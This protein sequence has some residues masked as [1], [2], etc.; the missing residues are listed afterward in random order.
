[1]DEEKSHIEYSGTDIL[2][3]FAGRL[4]AAEMHA[5]EKAALDDP[6]LL[7]T[8]LFF[9]S[10]HRQRRD[11]DNGAVNHVAELVGFQDDVER[12]VPRNLA[13]HEID[14]PLDLGIDDDVEAADLL[15]WAAE[16]KSQVGVLEVE[17]DGRT[18]EFGLG[19]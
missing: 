12:L 16:D 10:Q 9:S 18:G 7:A 2:N 19:R 5:L 3:Y 13:E 17:A 14:R 15:K 8:L 1:M 4:N 11:A 6:F